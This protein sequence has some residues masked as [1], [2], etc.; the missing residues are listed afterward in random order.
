[1]A[2]KKWRYFIVFFFIL[3]VVIVSIR[4]K[5]INED[6][7]Y[8]KA[9][10]VDV[11]AGDTVMIGSLEF[12][13]GEASE[14]QIA[15]DP[16]YEG[17][18]AA[19]YTLPINITRKND[20]SL[21]ADS[22]FAIYEHYE[23]YHNLVNIQENITTE[24]MQNVFDALNQFQVGESTELVITTNLLLGNFYYYYDNYQI[25]K[26]AYIVVVGGRSEKG[27]PIYYYEL[28]GDV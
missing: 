17:K 4:I 23:G 21:E 3:L 27:T 20:Q 5:V 1:M 26:P 15:L 8:Y 22:K 25:D 14:P 16:V 10:R 19:N 28:E 6:R 2:K 18:K 9:Y 13:F 11:E 24:A 7:E 12:Q